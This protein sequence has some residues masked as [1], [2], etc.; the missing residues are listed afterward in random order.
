MI[1]G[2]LYYSGGLLTICIALIYWY[3]LYNSVYGK[4]KINGEKH[5]KN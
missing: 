2:I 5:I 4:K 1:Y 3:S